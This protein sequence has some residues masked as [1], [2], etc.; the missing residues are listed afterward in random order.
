MNRPSSPS[1]GHKL[2]Q[3][4]PAQSRH[5][6]PRW[7]P[8]DSDSGTHAHVNLLPMQLLFLAAAVLAASAGYRALLLP[9]ILMIGLI[10]LIGLI[11]NL[12]RVRC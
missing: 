3:N 8:N 11:D 7:R 1:S 6:A 2:V 12:L 10:G 4:I 5:A 9:H